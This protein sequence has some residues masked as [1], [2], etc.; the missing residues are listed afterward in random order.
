MKKIALLLLIP[1]LTSCGQQ[2]KTSSN[3]NVQ[4]D[5]FGVFLG[6]NPSSLSR[7]VQ[8][9]NVIIDID[10]FSENDISYLK[11]NDC[12][13]YSYLSI[14]SLEKY[15]SYYETYKDLTFMD[16]DNWPDERWVDVSSNVWQNHLVDEANRFKDLKSDGIFMDNFDVYH[17]VKEEYECSETFKEDIFNGCIN[18]LDRLDETGLDLI[19]NSG[20]DFLERLNEEN[21]GELDKIDVYAQECVFS[22][23]VDYQKDIFGKQDE[24]TSSYYKSIVSFMKSHSE[25]LLIEYTKDDSLVSQVENYCKINNC[26]YY[27]SASVNL[28]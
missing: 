27:V 1:F 16:Y 4:N 14:G 21:N 10:E 26:Y 23:I 20:T 11:D 6:A 9:E 3:G 24:E 2:N 17:I 12:K 13:I 18:I 15:R 7:I 8:Y 22:S 25:I 5:D 19:I 28:I